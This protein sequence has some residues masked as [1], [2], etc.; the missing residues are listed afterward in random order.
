MLSYAHNFTI[1]S[2]ACALSNYLQ[3]VVTQ[4]IRI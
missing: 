4:Q 3:L 2:N 1:A